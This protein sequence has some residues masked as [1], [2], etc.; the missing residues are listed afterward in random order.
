MIAC[1]LYVQKMLL[2]VLCTLLVAAGLCGQMG[3]G[4]AEMR[5]I[6]HEVSATF[7]S[8]GAAIADVDNDGQKDILAGCYWYKA[9]NWTRYLIHA[10]TLNP[11]PG[12]STTFIN[13]SLD[14]NNDGRVD[15]IRFDQPGGICMWYE[16]PGNTPRLWK[17]RVLLALAGIENPA[18]ADVDNDGRNDL[19]CNDAAAKK[20]IW[21]KAPLLKNDTTWRVT[22]ISD[23]PQLAT[24]RYTHGLGVGDINNDG[25][26][27]VV[28]K[29]GWWQAM[30]NASQ[31]NWQFTAGNLGADCANMHILDCNGDG[32][33]DVIS[34]SA[35]N[36]GMW[37]F[38]QVKLADGTIQWKEHLI[39]KLFSQS[40][41]L[42]LKDIN[43]DGH[44]DLVTGKRYLAHHDGHDAGSYEPSV[45]YW[46]EFVPGKQPKWI[47]HLIDDNSGVGNSFEVADVNSDGLED[48]VVSNKKGVYYFEQL[49]KP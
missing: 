14:V 22:T 7:V 2:L 16:N 4:R 48:I 33:A 5:F 36:Y 31:S 43:N 1:R 39:S 13:F 12:Y 38:E 41:S 23:N 27:D 8:E 30:A 46:F 3:S 15:L 28:V 18:F 45:L 42:I 29:N 11:V 44:A 49:K 34:S 17:G 20:V 21:L 9:P 24:N 37:W 19:V 26:H 25:L 6:K 47:P 40:H 10:D 35:H 32:L